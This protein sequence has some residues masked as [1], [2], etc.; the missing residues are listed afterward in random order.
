[1]VHL[2]TGFVIIKLVWHTSVTPF[3]DD[4]ILGLSLTALIPPCSQRR[5]LLG[6]LM[7]TPPSHTTPSMHHSKQQGQGVL[8]STESWEGRWVGG[9]GGATCKGAW[10]M[11]NVY[12]DLHFLNEYDGHSPPIGPSRKAGTIQLEDLVKKSSQHRLASTV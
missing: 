12:V 2:E 7:V 1:V 9:D 11:P 8:Q 3:P 4:I 10:A 6:A 5:R